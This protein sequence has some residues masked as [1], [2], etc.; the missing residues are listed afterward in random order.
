MDQNVCG[1]RSVH[2]EDVQGIGRR[3][4]LHRAAAVDQKRNSEVLVDR[5]CD[6]VCAILYRGLRVTNGLLGF[7]LGFLSGALGL[8][9]LVAQYLADA[10]LDIPD[11]FVR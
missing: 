3:S 10:L 7:A 2:K 5:G 4:L 11:C 8:E 6:F 1:A 9:L